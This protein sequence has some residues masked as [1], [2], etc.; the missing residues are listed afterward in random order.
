MILT[1]LLLLLGTMVTVDIQID[2]LAGLIVQIR[3]I[4]AGA[5]ADVQVLAANP[6]AGVLVLEG[7]VLSIQEVAYIVATIL[8]VCRSHS[9]DF[10][11]MVLINTFFTAY[12]YRPRHCRPNGNRRPTP[13]Y[14]SLGYR[15]WV[16][17][18]FHVYT[19]QHIDS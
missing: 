2:V 14:H 8:Y 11:K 16:S 15:G 17:V 12:L 10:L 5:V 3:N 1:R 19:Q 4:V 7:R 6:V 13:S 9:E 18:F